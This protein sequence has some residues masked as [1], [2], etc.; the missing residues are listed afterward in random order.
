MTYK[1]PFVLHAKSPLPPA[2]IPDQVRVRSVAPVVE[3]ISKK[4]VVLPA[5][6]IRPSGQW[7]ARSTAAGILDEPTNVLTQS[8]GLS[9]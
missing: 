7:V 5:A 2:V 9:L 4:S 8:L 1:L 6:Y 3:L